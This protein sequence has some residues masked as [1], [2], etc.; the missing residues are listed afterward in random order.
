MLT[1]TSSLSGDFAAVA[2][3]LGK[4]P[5]SFL[6][7]ASRCPA[8]HPSVVMGYPLRYQA[9]RPVPFPSHLW[10]TCPRLS[11]QLSHLERQGCI[12]QLQRLLLNSPDLQRRFM[13][14]HRRCIDHRWRLLRRHDRHAIRCY[15]LMHVYQDRGIGGV[16]NWMSIKCLHLHYAHHLVLGDVIG[17]LLEQHD[18]ITP[19]G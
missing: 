5:H 14:D 12:G 4:R 8:G 3:Q 2:D 18:G 16:A 10:L 11:D 19:C 1:K 7:V 17:Q 15:G 13:H 9:N 6:S